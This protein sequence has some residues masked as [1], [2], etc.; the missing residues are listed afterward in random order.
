MKRTTLAAAVMAAA[1]LSLSGCGRGDVRATVEIGGS[2]SVAPAIELLA[3]AYMEAHP[4][5]R[6]NVNGTGSSDGIRNA[7][8]LYQF[9]MTSRDLT[10][11][12][13]GMGLNQRVIA[14]DGI[15]VIVHGSSPLHDLSLERI[16]AIYT[17]EITDWSEISDSKSG[18]IAVVTREEGSG[19]RG[20]FEELAGFPGGLRAGAVEGPSTGA[21]RSAVAG[22]PNAIGYVSLGSVDSSVRAISVDGVDAT[23]EN[24]RS[25][26]YRI[27]RPFILLYN[28][29]RPAG[30]AFLDWV[31]SDEGQSIVAGNWMPIN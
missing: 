31:V 3:A 10:P 8:V 14:I 1:A 2:T 12:E 6:I 21:V 20:A 7:G 11:A 25:G 16:R 28:D 18:P 22:N 27:A 24:I 5:V 9:G 26:A 19:T 15:A 23:I 13:L 17:G 4:D 30:V 29:P